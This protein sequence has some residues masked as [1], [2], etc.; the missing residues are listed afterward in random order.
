MLRSISSMVNLAA[1]TLAI[2]LDFT[3]DLVKYVGVGFELQRFL[4]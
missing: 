2:C 4:I 1:A 3:D